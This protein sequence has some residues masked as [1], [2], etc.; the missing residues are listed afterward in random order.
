MLKRLDPLCFFSTD[1]ASLNSPGPNY[2]IW[3]I[4]WMDECVDLHEVYLEIS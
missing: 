4:K 3:Q 1:L 2:L